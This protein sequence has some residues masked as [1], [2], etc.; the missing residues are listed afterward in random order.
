MTDPPEMGSGKRGSWWP[1]P[2][3]L[4]K[5]LGDVF[6]LQHRIED[7]SQQNDKLQ[8]QISH[9]QRQIDDHNGQIAVIREFMTSA[10]H[11][12]AARSAERAAM[13]AIRAFLEDKR[14]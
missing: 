12:T 11:Q 5:F 9:L 8:L 14:K 13:D 6:R 3:E 10:I 4:F 1:S 7:L 2:K